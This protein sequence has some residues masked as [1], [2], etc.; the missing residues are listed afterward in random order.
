[1]LNEEMNK[2]VDD[3]QEMSK[4]V[5]EGGL[6]DFSELLHEIY[7]D[8]AYLNN[9]ETQENCRVPFQKLPEANKKTMNTLA[10]R[11]RRLIAVLEEKAKEEVVN[12]KNIAYE[13][14]IRSLDIAYEKRIRSL[15]IENNTKRDAE[16]HK[17]RASAYR[18]LILKMLD[19]RF[20]IPYEWRK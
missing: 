7:E 1:M 13:K 18:G 20:S 17:G 4:V 3:L 5:K 14:R 11:L 2:I 15:E 10:M 16:F 19:V 8:S 6:E 9:W 12:K